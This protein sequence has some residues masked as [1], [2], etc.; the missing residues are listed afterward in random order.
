MS[1]VAKVANLN[2]LEVSVSVN[3]PTKTQMKAGEVELASIEI[4]MVRDDE[5]LADKRFDYPEILGRLL[6]GPVI[7]FAERDT[8]ARETFRLES[9]KIGRDIPDWLPNEI[10]YHVLMTSQATFQYLESQA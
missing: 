4:F 1:D 9:S 7:W 3:E 2:V 5:K 8:P 6:A 10:R